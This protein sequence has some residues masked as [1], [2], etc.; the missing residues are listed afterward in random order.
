LWKV[1][2]PSVG[3]RFSLFY[4]ALFLQIGITLPFWPIVLASRGLDPTAIGL[5]GA[6]AP[7]ARMVVGPLLG[8]AFDR[9]RLG[10][11]CLFAVAAL[12]ALGHIGFGLV[13]GFWP[14]LLLTLLVAPLYPSIPPIVDAH[15][16]R[17]GE[18]RGLDFG[19]M[20]L[21]GSM[22]FIVAN[23]V[24]GWLIVGAGG[25]M[26]L[27][28][29]VGATFLGGLAAPLLPP[30]NK[31]PL[32]TGAER[33]SVGPAPPAPGTRPDWRMAGALLRKR[34]FL[35]VFLI[36]GSIQATHAL[37]YGFGT[38]GWRAQGFS[39]ESIGLL[40]AVGVAAEVVFLSQTKTLLRR[41]GADGLLLL[42]GVTCVLR[43]SVMVFEP[44][45]E[46]LFVLQL[47]HAFTFAATYIGGVHLVQ[48]S[49]PRN[50]I[51]TGQ[52]LFAAL[53][54]GLLFASATAASGA[55]FGAYGSGAFVA[56]A[57]VAAAGAVAAFLLLR[58]RSNGAAS[59]P[60]SPTTPAPAEP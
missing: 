25:H 30:L 46:L 2:G 28:L 50:L 4:W 49:V 47:L 24:C 48:Q 45:L 26:I 14:V 60:V 1:I 57:A 7:A 40:W 10:R 55:L 32:P 41:F 34:S 53:S 38:L 42:G 9:Y 18:S 12:S 19:R 17:M 13:Q 5:V 59:T 21:W 11:G 23:L 33:P 43:W 20:R 3:L 31:E 58:R 37:L 44:P 51:A 22:G 29:V 56:P 6:A 54:A 36:A 39:E 27:A 16:I 52:A 15:A 35:T 8:F